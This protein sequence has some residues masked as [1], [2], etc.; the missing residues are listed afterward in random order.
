MIDLTLSIHYAELFMTLLQAPTTLPY[1]ANVVD[2]FQ[3]FHSSLSY[4]IEYILPSDWKPSCYYISLAHSNHVT[5]VSD[6]TLFLLS[7]TLIPA[8]LENVILYS[9]N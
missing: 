3:A 1:I 5:T 8:P 2:N 7:S 4:I 9:L 6:E